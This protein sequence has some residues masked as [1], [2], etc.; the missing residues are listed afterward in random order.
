[1]PRPATIRTDAILDAARK[2]FLRHGYKASTARVAREA[3]VSEGSLFKRFRNKMDLFLAA[4]AAE[5]RESPWEDDLMRSVG[6]G[7]LRATLESAGMRI[8]EDL[9]VSL[10][11]IIM[12]RSSGLVVGGHGRPDVYRGPGPREKMR[13][14]SRYFRAET[15]AG[16]LA[17]AKPE[18]EA[19]IF[20]STLTQY[21]IHEMLFGIRSASPAVYVRTVVNMIV[22]AA[23]PT[24]G[25]KGRRA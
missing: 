3:G 8:L 20:L 10:P 5:E 11:R 23:A 12:V 21:V 1:M 24:A 13:V 7:D 19:Q 4:M 16:R 18:V 14:L 17:I 9:Q 15:K 25:R 2:V 6:K 22:H